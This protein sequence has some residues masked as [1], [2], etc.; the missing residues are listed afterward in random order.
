[1]NMPA[2]GYDIYGREMYQFARPSRWA[3]GTV[4][5]TPATGRPSSGRGWT[6][7]VI[8]EVESEDAEPNCSFCA[9]HHSQ[10]QH[11]LWC[12]IYPFRYCNCGYGQP[13]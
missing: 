7:S 11:R 3:V 13:T 4:T 8:G 5:L 1:M 6:L 12:A 2:L 10:S 9:A